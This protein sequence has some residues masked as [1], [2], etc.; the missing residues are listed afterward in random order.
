MYTYIYHYMYYTHHKPQLWRLCSP[1]QLTK[2]GAPACTTPS[3]WQLSQACCPEYCPALQ[4]AC[5][6]RD[7]HGMFHHIQMSF[8]PR[9]VDKQRGLSSPLA[10]G[11]ED[12]CYTKPAPLVL[13]KEH[14]CLSNRDVYH[15]PTDFQS[16]PIKMQTMFRLVDVCLAKNMDSESTKRSF[17][18]RIVSCYLLLHL[19]VR[20][21]LQLLRACQ[22]GNHGPYRPNMGHILPLRFI[23]HIQTLRIQNDFN[24]SL[25]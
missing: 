17:G 21:V 24:L 4:A 23:N 22:K 12:R 11:D 18:I 9:L 8:S 1:T 7:D 13:P 10:T 5:R 6:S 20:L 19:V 25:L 3:T 15:P 16:S 14:C 2:L